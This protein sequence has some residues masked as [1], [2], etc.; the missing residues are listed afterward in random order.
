MWGAVQPHL[1]AVLCGCKSWGPDRNR[2]FEV[3]VPVSL[4]SFSETEGALFFPPV[5][6]TLFLVLTSALF[7]FALCTEL[8]S[9]VWLYSE[10]E[11]SVSCWNLGLVITKGYFRFKTLWKTFFIAPLKSFS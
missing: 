1:S 3:S 10:G 6:C 8:Q 7:G 5:L 4:F 2:M 9:S 11:S